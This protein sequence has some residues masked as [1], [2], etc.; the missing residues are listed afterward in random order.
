[1]QILS[2]WIT[3][4]LKITCYYITKI[5]VHLNSF[6][7]FATC[8]DSQLSAGKT[9]WF[10]NEFLKFLYQSK[11][12]LSLRR[13]CAVPHVLIHS[14]LQG[15]TNCFWNANLKHSKSL[16]LVS[17]KHQPAFQEFMFCASCTDSQFS[18]G[19]I[20]ICRNELLKHCKSLISINISHTSTSFWIVSCVVQADV[21]LIQEQVILSISKFHLKNSWFYLQKAVNQYMRHNTWNSSITRWVFTDIITSYFRSIR[22]KLHLTLTNL[23]NLYLDVQ[24]R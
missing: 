5:N 11:I 7:C 1:M 22:Q 24:N 21:W 4:T 10:W 3:E 12:N 6:L 2:G 14:S 8:T 9:N 20:N 15:K 23:D 13:S 19:K 17:V 16:V 18:E